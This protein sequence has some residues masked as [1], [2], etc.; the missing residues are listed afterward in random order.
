MLDTSSRPKLSCFVSAMQPGSP[1]A[2]SNYLPKA[3]RPGTRRYRPPYKG[4]SVLTLRADAS[5]PVCPHYFGWLV[6]EAGR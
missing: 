1:A 3:G 2:T 5:T 6:S 4:R